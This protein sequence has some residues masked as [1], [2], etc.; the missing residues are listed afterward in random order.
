MSSSQAVGCVIEKDGIM[1]AHFDHSKPDIESN[2]I[3]K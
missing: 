1:R 3:K 2:S